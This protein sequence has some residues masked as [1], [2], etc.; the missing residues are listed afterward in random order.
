MKELTKADGGFR[1]SFY[2]YLLAGSREKSNSWV[3]ECSPEYI[4]RDKNHLVL[5]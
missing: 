3:N 2:F 5:E 1:T 4:E